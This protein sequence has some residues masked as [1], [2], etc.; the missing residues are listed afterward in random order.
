MEICLKA[1]MCL[2]LSLLLY[3]GIYVAFVYAGNA[4]GVNGLTTTTTT[5]TTTATSK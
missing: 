3:V 1:T 4:Q 5:T 2:N